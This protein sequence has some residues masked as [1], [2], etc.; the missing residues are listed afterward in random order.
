MKN[1]FTNHILRITQERHASSTIEFALVA[2][3]MIAFFIALLELPTI[4]FGH[5]SIVRISSEI[6]MAIRADPERLLREKDIRK[7]ACDASR[8]IIGCS[9]DRMII[10]INP[11]NMAQISEESNAY[12][13]SSNPYVADRIVIR[14]KWKGIIT[15]SILNASDKTNNNK[16]MFAISFV[17][18]DQIKE[19]ETSCKEKGGVLW[20]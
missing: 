3:V 10:Q 5:A 2:P 8:I 16:E 11:S 13:R 15:I 6:S 12:L 1:R 17:I 7:I 18:P 4:A 14:Y 20:C 9:N 19:V